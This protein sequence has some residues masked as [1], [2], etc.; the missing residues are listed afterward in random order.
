M[1]L[2]FF[3]ACLL[4][5]SEEHLL[6]VIAECGSLV[7]VDDEA[8]RPDLNILVP[9]RLGVENQLNHGPLLDVRHRVDCLK[10]EAV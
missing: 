6:A 9:Q 4:E 1:A 7:A 8:V 5:H 3:L 10:R 2:R